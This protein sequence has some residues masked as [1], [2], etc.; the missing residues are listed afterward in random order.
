MCAL[1]LSHVYF[2]YFYINFVILFS[3]H[4]LQH[5]NIATGFLSDIFFYSCGHF[6]ARLSVLLKLF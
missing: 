1:L 3:P 4:E 2:I 6:L 5:L